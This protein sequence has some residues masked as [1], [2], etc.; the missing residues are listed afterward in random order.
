MGFKRSLRLTIDADHHPTRAQR[1]KTKDERL[2]A[3]GFSIRFRV[4]NQEPVWLSP[5]GRLTPE[6]V[7]LACLPEEE[8]PW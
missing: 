3:A 5:S 4:G 8:P 2:R 1:G 7:A 6:H